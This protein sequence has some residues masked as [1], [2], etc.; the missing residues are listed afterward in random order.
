MIIFHEGLPGA[1]KSYEAC[2]KFIIPALLEGRKVFA[3]IEGLNHEKFAEVTKL[4]LKLVQN[5]LVQVERDQV[6]QIHELVA[7]DSLVIIDEVQNFWPTRQLPKEDPIIKFVAEHRHN[8]LDIVVMGQDMRDC[9]AIWKRRVEQKIVF[10]KL[11]AVGSEN[12]YRWQ[13]YRAVS[14]EKFL[15][16]TSGVE[17]YKREY[18]GL[19][20]SHTKGT[21]NTRTFKDGRAVIWKNPAL[22]YGVPL[23]IFLLFY[24][25]NGLYSFF[26]PETFSVQA[27]TSIPHSSPSGSTPV[28]AEP[29]PSPVGSG[30]AVVP[31]VGGALDRSPVK[32]VDS[33]PSPSPDT[34]VQEIPRETD[35]LVAANEKWRVRLSGSLM[36]SDRVA[37][38]IEFYDN[39]YRLQQRFTS[40]QLELM[41][42]DLQVSDG[43]GKI[44]RENVVIFVNS[45][46]IEPLGQVSR[47]TAQQL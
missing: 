29:G 46:P 15:P 43:I 42:W 20:S 31:P 45:W 17:T 18:F 3:Y 44:T 41:G 6:L 13:L 5:L 23:F 16:V 10:T 22:K 27:E 30:G 24:G 25:V 40:D 38:V 36:A 2:V 32:Q 4:P 28:V 8:G 19:Y 37:Y 9:N 35:L 14:G 1:G 26:H 39:S 33:L 21:L 34:D 12:R 47:Q 11:T 7:K